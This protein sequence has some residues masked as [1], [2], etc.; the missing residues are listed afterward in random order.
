M[1]PDWKD[2]LQTN[3]ATFYSDRGICFQPSPEDSINKLYA[4]PELAVL[5]VS[6]TDADTFLQGQITCDINLITETKGGLGAFCSVKGRTI[7]TFLLL[8]RS[9]SYWLIL[10]NELLESIKQRLQM[11]ILRADVQLTDCSKKL[12]LIGLSSQQIIADLPHAIYQTQQQA[13]VI[14]KYPSLINRYLIIAELEDAIQQ[15]ELYSKQ[16]AFNMTDSRA[17]TNDDITD[18]IPWLNKTTSEEFIPQMLNLDQ[19]GGISFKKG[20]Y[21]GQEIVARTHYL[22]KTKRQMYLA[23]SQTEDIPFANSAILDVNTGNENSIGKV[24]IAQQDNQLCRMLVVLQT[25]DIKS[26]SL[27]LNNQNQDRISISQLPQLKL[28]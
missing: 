15:W 9:T 6:G 1:N 25:S 24:L 21:T 26:K 2:F 19:L 20:C 7:S 17:W 4:V 22:G 11:Y 23:E 27:S 14:I 28:N 12:C 13:F 3:N 8:K 18:G 5:A 16:Y 10:P